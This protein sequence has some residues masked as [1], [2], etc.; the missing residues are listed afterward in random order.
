[1]C[2]NFSSFLFQLIMFFYNKS[3]IYLGVSLSCI[4]HFSE[5]E[6]KI[7]DS[8]VKNVYTTIFNEKNCTFLRDVRWIKKKNEN[9]HIFL[10]LH[11]SND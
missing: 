1:M 8:Q 2:F 3:D 7:D 10:I 4:G 9:K 5:C 11:F 6:F